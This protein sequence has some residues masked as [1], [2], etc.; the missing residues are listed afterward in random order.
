M[1]GA[2]GGMWLHRCMLRL[3]RL[4]QPA[5]VLLQFNTPPPSPI[6]LCGHREHGPGQEHNSEQGSRAETGPC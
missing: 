6:L 2:K 1:A 5:L 3:H 4:L